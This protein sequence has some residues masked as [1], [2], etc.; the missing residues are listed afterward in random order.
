M[1][2]GLN[3]VGSVASLVK[4]LVYLDKGFILENLK[5]LSLVGVDHMIYLRL[6]AISK[7]AY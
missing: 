2:S 6:N 7:A 1:S 3:F 5:V 4:F